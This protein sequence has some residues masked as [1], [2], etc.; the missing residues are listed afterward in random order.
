MVKFAAGL[1]LSAWQYELGLGGG[2]VQRLEE[3]MFPRLQLQVQADDRLLVKGWK[4]S[5][6]VPLIESLVADRCCPCPQWTSNLVL[7]SKLSSQV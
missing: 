5:W 4:G 3:V 6:R 2:K 7:S 1:G